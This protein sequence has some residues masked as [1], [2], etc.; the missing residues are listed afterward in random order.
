MEVLL[1]LGN[2]CG[3]QT[4]NTSRCSKGFV[5][6]VCSDRVD[7]QVNKHLSK[8]P[9]WMPTS[10]CAFLTVVRNELPLRIVCLSLSVL[11]HE[12]SP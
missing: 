5:R 7:I 3:L 9:K 4:K 6:I 2:L 1:I 12:Y 10:L 8:V 11:K